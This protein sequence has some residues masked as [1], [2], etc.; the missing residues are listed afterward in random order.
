MLGGLV[1][2][3]VPFLYLYYPVPSVRSTAAMGSYGSCGR[4]GVRLT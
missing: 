4:V 3:C 2:R 1:I